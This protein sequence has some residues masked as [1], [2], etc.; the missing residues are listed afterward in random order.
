M[1]NNTGDWLDAH[2]VVALGICKSKW[3]VYRCVRRGQLPLPVMVAGRKLWLRRD[4]E[5]FLLN[6][7]AG[8]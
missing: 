5:R 8:A 6:G 7:R 4:L 3:A 2:G 1:K